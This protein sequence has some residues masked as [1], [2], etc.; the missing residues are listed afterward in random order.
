MEICVNDALK[1]EWLYLCMRLLTV[2]V[3]I[4]MFFIDLIYQ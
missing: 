1:Q 4:F 3:E 2:L